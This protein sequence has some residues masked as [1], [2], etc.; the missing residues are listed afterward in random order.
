M[1]ATLK[2]ASWWL[3][4]ALFPIRD[5]LGVT[6]FGVPLRLNEIWMGAESAALIYRK[7]AHLDSTA[8]RLFVILLMNLLLFAV[9]TATHY[10]TV[11][12]SYA[13]KYLARQVLYSFFLFAVSSS[14]RRYDRH[15]FE[16]LFAYM[17]LVQLLYFVFTFV[18]GG[19]FLVGE[20]VRNDA[21]PSNIAIIA[22]R[23]VL[24]FKG[25]C[26]ES[27]Y[28]LPFLIIPLY[29][30]F[31]RFVDK[32]DN[33]WKKPLPYLGVLLFL[34]AMTFSTAIYAMILLTIPVVAW[35]RRRDGRVARLL[36]AALTV[37]IAVGLVTLAVP[38]LRNFF[39]I[40]VIEKI[41]AFAS[42]G[43]N[44]AFYNYSALDRSQHI[45]NAL[46]FFRTGTV[47]EKLFGHGTG[48]YYYYS[49]GMQDVLMTSANEAYNLYLSTLTDRGLLGLVLLLALFYTVRAL[50]VKGDIVSEALYWGFFAQLLHWFLN[51][52]LWLSYFWY[53]I[54][55]LMGYKRNVE[56]AS[57]ERNGISCGICE[58]CQ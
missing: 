28:A 47:M 13:L 16:R 30:Y 19:Y 6:L 29:Y 43:K 40:A 9:G 12:H 26:S 24:R 46:N 15:F 7:R 39:Y 36:W 41:L 55:F 14:Q 4:M 31:N 50:R 38:A 34:S 57:N 2:K 32:E 37:C 52:M 20:F 3:D 48:A 27:G 10:Q 1:Q 11:V 22:G 17:T 5:A 58:P 18:S 23:P 25:F 8:R 53:I 33:A 35:R 42:Q 51:G 49:S 54:V 56:G 44:A 45:A 21:L